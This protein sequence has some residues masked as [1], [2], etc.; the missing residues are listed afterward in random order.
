MMR[1]TKMTI[2]FKKAALPLLSE[3][4]ICY[5]TFTSNPAM[6]YNTPQRGK[7]GLSSHEDVLLPQVY[8]V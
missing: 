8:I 5:T 1:V 7:M 2:A 6:Y 4:T 3:L